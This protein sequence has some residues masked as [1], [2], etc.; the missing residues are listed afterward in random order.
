MRQFIFTTKL[1][2]FL[3]L[4]IFSILVELIALLYSY[5][6]FISMVSGSFFTALLISITDKNKKWF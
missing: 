3:S 6:F 1:G 4:F 2:H 5:S